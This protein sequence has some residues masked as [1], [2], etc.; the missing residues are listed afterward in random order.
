MCARIQVMRRAHTRKL[1]AHINFPSRN[2]SAHISYTLFQIQ[3]SSCKMLQKKIFMRTQR[4]HWILHTF[5]IACSLCLY[6]KKS[7]H[8]LYVIEL[9]Q[10]YS[11]MPL[12]TILIDACNR[13]GNT[14]LLWSF[15]CLNVCM[16]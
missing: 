14:F 3:M 11:V 12:R 13:R 15:Y 16:G 8:I 9:S 6:W 4:K 2:V 10:N 5:C 7:F 1:G